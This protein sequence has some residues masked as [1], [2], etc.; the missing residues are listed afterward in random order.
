VIDS[1]KDALD[2]DAEQ[3]YPEVP[4]LVALKKLLDEL[5]PTEL[6]ARQALADGIAAELGH[7]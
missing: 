2:W 6:A 3:H 4:G 5:Q 1:E 7:R